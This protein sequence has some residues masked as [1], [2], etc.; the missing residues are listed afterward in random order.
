MRTYRFML[1]LFDAERG[2][3]RLAEV[4]ISNLLVG[5][6]QGYGDALADTDHLPVF[7]VRAGNWDGGH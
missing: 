3:A 5:N 4:E 1:F 6:G 7:F 2:F